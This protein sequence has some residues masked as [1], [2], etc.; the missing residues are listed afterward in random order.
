MA[1]IF[2][3]T[4][5]LEDPIFLGSFGLAVVGWIVA[6]AGQCASDLSLRALGADGP[7]SWF[8]IFFNMSV[9]VGTLAIVSS[10]KISQYR[11]ALMAF[12]ATCLVLD[13]QAISVFIHLDSSYQAAGA[14]YIFLSIVFIVWIMVLGSD[15]QQRSKAA[16][17]SSSGVIIG[18]N[19]TPTMIPLSQATPSNVS[20]NQVVVSP[21]AEYA[22]KAR[23]LYDYTASPEDPNELNFNKDDV[24]DIVDNKGKWWQA[25]RADGVIGIVPSNYL[26]II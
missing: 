9:I 6:L 21:N 7:F 1:V 8:I 25:R 13:S 2:D 4:Q 12:F 22:Y 14:G 20:Q 10:S 3:F 24:L 23:A 18:N 15:N 19:V 16:A 17:Y 5:L 26:Q 11:P